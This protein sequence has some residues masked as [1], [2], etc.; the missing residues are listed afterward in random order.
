MG[1]AVIAQFY[2]TLG[3]AVKRVEELKRLH[4]GK[5][6]WF[7]IEASNGCLVIDE[8]QARKCFPDLLEL[9]SYKHRRYN[10]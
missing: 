6:A 2:K 5:I 7:V 9:K 4:R 3:L 10:N 1:K 8:G